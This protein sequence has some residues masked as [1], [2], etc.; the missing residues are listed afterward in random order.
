MSGTPANASLWTDADVYTA[1][2]GTAL[3]ATITDPFIAA[4]KQL[5]LL[6]GDDGFSEAREED[7]GDHFGWGGVLL[8]TTRK[9][10]KLTKKFTLLEDNTDTR[11]LIWP[12]S[13]A[14][15]LVVP[16]PVNILLALE[17]REGTKKR[18]VITALY[19]QV[20]VD[21]DITENE[22]DITKYPMIA[23]IF[24]TAASPAVLWTEQKSA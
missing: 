24:P 11:A 7:V 12:G 19:A 17:T 14:G 9:N 3:P 18:R 5:G 21:G 10:F 16:K 22:S 2:I 4:W 8:R 23:T 1:P 15:S 20:T 13:P 6:D